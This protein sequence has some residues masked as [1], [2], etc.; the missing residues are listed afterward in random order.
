MNLN[1]SSVL[2]EYRKKI[3]SLAKHRSAVTRQVNLS[4][5]APRKQGQ[6]KLGV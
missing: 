5:G 1:I 6:G 2:R 3:K 4:H